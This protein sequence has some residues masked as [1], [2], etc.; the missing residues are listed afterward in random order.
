MTNMLV[1]NVKDKRG[2]LAVLGSS[3]TIFW[4]GVFIFGFPGIMGRYWQECL[5][6]GKGE[7]GN[8]MFFV[9]SAVGIFMFLVGKWQERFGIKN[10]IA[11]GSILCALSLLL[12]LNVRSILRL[13]LWAFLVGL[14]SC[15][16]YIP[17]LTTVQTWFPSVRGLVSGIVNFTFGI[18][19][20]IMSPILVR[21]LG[22]LGYKGTVWTILALA[23]VTGVIFSQFTEA[24][25]KPG[26]LKKG[27]IETGQS[28]TVRESL[29][30]RSFWL[31][32]LVWALQGAS[33]IS[34]VTLSVP[35][36]LSLGFGMGLSVSILTAFNLTN[37]ISRIV[38]GFLSDRMGRKL[39]MSLTF[40]AASLS[41]ALLPH[42]GK[43]TALI[44]TLA[45]A[46]GFSFGT[47]F[48]VSAPLASEVFGLLH[49][50]AIFGMVFTAYGFISGIIGP[51]LSGYILDRTGGNFRIV[52]YYLGAFSMISS[53]LILFVKNPVKS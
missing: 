42:V 53:L 3:A 40:L 5:H 17:A 12:I 33:G 19:A 22:K 24:P 37:G 31:L 48:A 30:T 49:F 50:G 39:T 34:M 8:I 20:A 9:L 10:M 16:I 2:F 13:Y 32:W 21:M 23:L 29:K 35:F 43:N 15:F 28:L 11:T 47:L 14:S 41:Y 4:P 46:I 36:G 38:T 1:S 6:V 27:R 45:S 26:S 25:W 7:I 52:F 51:S 44:Y 18:S